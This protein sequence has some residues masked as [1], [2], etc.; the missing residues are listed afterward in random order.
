MI[1]YISMISV[2]KLRNNTNFELDGAPYRVLSYQHTHM[3]RGGGSVKVRIRN[4]ADGSVLSKTFQ[5][6]EKVDD[7]QVIKKKMQFLYRDDTDLVFM[8]PDTYEQTTVS[9]KTLED[10]APY[11]KEGEDVH[12]LIWDEE[13]MILGVDLPPKMTFTVAEAAPGEK[14][15]S[16]S[17]V[18]KDAILENG[19]K[20]RVPLF[21][22]QGDKIRVDTRDG[23]YVERA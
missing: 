15:D 13:E 4:L 7:I 23:S 20:V 11:L 12:L 21:V 3:S 6:T 14:G 18:Y 10:Q 19:L 8:D 1:Q 2:T 22:N 17:N 5:S 16:A 9:L